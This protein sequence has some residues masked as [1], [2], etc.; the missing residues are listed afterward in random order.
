MPTNV[1]IIYSLSA[2]GDSKNG[3]VFRMQSKAMFRNR[4]DA[5]AYIPEFRRLCT[6]PAFLECAEEEGLVITVVERELH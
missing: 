1:E 4:E 3:W 2:K 6:D 5:E